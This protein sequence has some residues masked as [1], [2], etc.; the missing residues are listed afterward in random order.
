M[1]EGSAPY[2]FFRMVVLMGG[3]ILAGMVQLAI[4]PAMP[5]MGAHF[6]GDGHDGTLIAQYVTTI[7]ALSMGVGGPLAGIAAG[8]F[9]KRWVLL[10]S[11]LT[12]GIT[13]GIGAYA[14]DLFTLLASRLLLGIAA[15]GYVTVGVALLGDYYPEPAQRDRLIGWF[16]I[17]GGAGS[18]AVLKAA[19]WLTEQGGWHGPF[20]LYLSGI[21]LF[22]IGLFTITEPRREAVLATAGQWA[23]V[24]RAWGIY[25]MLILVSISMYTVTIQ[26]TFLMNEEGFT[27]PG[28]IANVMLMTSIG[29]VVGAYVFRFVRPALGFGL[30]LALTWALLA[31]GNAGF[32]STLNVWLLAAFAGLVG[33]GSGFNTPLMTTAVMG[34]VPPSAAANA[35]GV[36][37][38]CL[39][40]GQFLHPPALTPFRTAFGLHGAFLWM[41]GLSLLL[42]VLSALWSLR[43]RQRAVA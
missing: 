14:P 25:V 27:D 37:M 35:V 26:G 24:A 32:A 6:A 41:G 17:I 39:F 22:L 3:A 9:G 30:T 1:A 36:S 4:L 16:T 19:A 5:D 42:A 43:G 11:A 2:R 20:A 7:S 33:I 21:P 12:Y 13:G 29:T 31:L 23:P 10:I 28:T 38:G 15:S 18:L 40:L 8:R 34:A